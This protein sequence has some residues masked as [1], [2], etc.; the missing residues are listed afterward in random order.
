VTPATARCGRAGVAAALAIALH[1]ALFALGCGPRGDDAA[2]PPRPIAP[3]VSPATGFRFAPPPSWQADR[4][5]VTEISGPLAEKKQPGAFAVAEVQFQPADLGHRPEV[6]LRIR[7][8]P[9]SA[10]AAMEDDAGASL[11]SILARARGRTYLVETPSA[12]P[13]PPGSA[14]AAVFDA[15]H[16][17]L[18]D[19]KRWLTVADA[20]GDEA[21]EFLPGGSTFG[22]APVMYVGTLPASG[23]RP[24]PVKVIFRAD[25]SALFSTQYPGRGVVNE[26]G[27]W[28]LQGAYLRLQM[29]DE[30]GL[31]TRV[32]FIWA[33]RDSALAPVAW[34]EA[35]YG[36][37]GVPLSWRP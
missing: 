33:L 11:G 29:L 1:S 30:S 16:L 31:P 20:A 5:L 13:Y 19:V 37:V 8:F 26:R 14:D 18:A 34:D 3:Y 35:H 15:M 6:L 25:S 32:P 23:G 7:V 22:P 12:T 17:A 21:S 4:Y 28:S 10:W 27:R 24:R 9:D 2:A 36:S